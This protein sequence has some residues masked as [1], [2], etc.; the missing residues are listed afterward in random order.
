[1]SIK[2]PKCNQSEDVVLI[3]GP[4]FCED[5]EF[6]AYFVCENCDTS[7]YARFAIQLT[8]LEEITL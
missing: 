7:F 2:C 1:M 3:D 4:K 8:E 5:S 6:V